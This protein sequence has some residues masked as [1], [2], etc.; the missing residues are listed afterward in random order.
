MRLATIAYYVIALAL[1]IFFMSLALP[2]L[3]NLLPGTKLVYVIFPVIFIL[4]THYNPREMLKAFKLA[5]RKSHGTKAEYKNALLFFK[6][7]Q[8]SLDIYAY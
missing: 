8:H 1:L 3:K 6:T 2:F 7:I 4:L 5:G